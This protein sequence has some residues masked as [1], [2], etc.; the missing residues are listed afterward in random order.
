ML[1]AASGE[2]HGV[3]PTQQVLPLYAILLHPSKLPGVHYLSLLRS[4]AVVVGKIGRGAGAYQDSR[5]SE[6][7]RH[8]RLAAR[9]KNADFYFGVA[10]GQRRTD[11][12]DIADDDYVDEDEDRDQAERDADDLLVQG[13][14]LRTLETVL[15]SLEGHSF[16]LEAAR[17]HA[18]HEEAEGF[19]F[20]EAPAG[21]A[22]MPVAQASAP[23]PSLSYDLSPL[24]VDRISREAL[25]HGLGLQ[26]PAA[27]AES[28]AAAKPGFAIDAR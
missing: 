15:T 8:D 24:D 12:Q 18:E 10:R 6:P 23:A 4:G 20:D 11:V 1:Q 2:H 14:D 7:D 17:L 22:L 25:S 9:L 16:D 5:P 26:G 21:V 13:F 19:D 3:V 28:V 27:Q